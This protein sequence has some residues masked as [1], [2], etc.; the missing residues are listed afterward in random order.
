MVAVGILLSRIFGLLR[1]RVL[2]H[3]LGLSDAGDAFAAAFRIPNFLQNLLGEGV[4]SASFIPVYA[5]LRAEGRND[6]AR[7]LAEAVFGVLALVTS[8]V[9]LLG[10]VFATPL[11]R[12]LALGF[13]ASK[14]VLT[15]RLVRILFPGAGL[16]VLSAWC[17]GVL[18]SHG[19]FL[20]AYTAP[21]VWNVAI[22]ASL[23]LSR[24]NGGD[25]GSAVAA[26][27]GSVV[28]ST[29]QFGVQLP[30]V[31]ALL[32]RLRPALRTRSSGM[33]TV[34]ANF[35]TVLIGRG[36][37]QISGFVDTMLA[38]LLGQGAVAG[39]ASAQVLYTLPVSLFGMSVAASELPAM[40]REIGSDAEVAA[41][42][43]ARL[44]LG[45]RRIAFFVVPSAVAF[46]AFGGT[47]AGAL[48]QT[49]RFTTADSRYVWTILA[50]STV[51]L[52]AGTMGRLYGSSYY[53]LGDPRTPLRFAL[54]RVA[55]TTLL[56]YLCAVPLPRAVGIDPRW[57]VVGLT[58][59]AGVA[60]WLEYFLLKRGMDA[61]IG[62]TGV[63]GRF[64][65]VLWSAALASAGAAYGVA[66]LLTGAHPI[67]RA[68]AVLAILGFTYL[69]LTAR[70]GVPESRA[71]ADAILRR[72]ARRHSRS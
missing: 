29:L 9:V 12:V 48:F 32:G 71:V 22:I 28:G 55:L 51:G 14:L 36:A 52:L 30:I 66:H 47:I 31:F 20:L 64:L 21:V 1:Q 72:G 15:V 61:R 56:G 8:I 68:T 18:N 17:L 49:G 42:L 39:L 53:A 11:T 60:A 41:A 24:G 44:G 46:L 59:S 67:P 4:L 16:L 40:S 3:Y 10:I 43:R 7:H 54:L 25:G 34:I 65:L 63:P 6:E 38:S 62:K 23:L 50:G 19:R 13:P 2:S 33:R 27:W 26:A 58:A 35:G 69:A 37:T 57:G 70:A 45:L 5:R